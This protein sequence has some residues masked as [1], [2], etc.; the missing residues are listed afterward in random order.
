VPSTRYERV[1]LA[2]K[3]VRGLN[4]SEGAPTAFSCSVYLGLVHYGSGIPKSH[5]AFYNASEVALVVNGRLRWHRS[6]VEFVMAFSTN[7]VM[8]LR[9]ELELLRNHRSEADAGIEAIELLLAN[10]R[11]NPRGPVARSRAHVSEPGRDAAASKRSL[12]HTSSLRV[13]VLKTLERVSKGTVADLT[14]HLHAEGVR[15]GGATSLR[16]RV[17]HELSRLRRKGMVRRYRNGQYTLRFFQ[18]P[19]NSNSGGSHRSPHGAKAV[20]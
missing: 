16:E 11:V 9:R 4:R 12:R 14:T 20:N 7:V 8:E 5:T 3:A 18:P 19:A 13:N 6:L 17:A 2:E 1:L 10:E 15:V